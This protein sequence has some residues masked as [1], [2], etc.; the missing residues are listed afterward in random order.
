MTTQVAN[1]FKA[2]DTPYV[3]PT[4][5]EDLYDFSGGGNYS[6]HQDNTQK[7]RSSMKIRKKR[8]LLECGS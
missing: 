6:L 1:L 2:I 8:F 5:A 4:A 3:K 7:S